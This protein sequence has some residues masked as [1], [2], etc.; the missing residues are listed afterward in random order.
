MTNAPKPDKARHSL[1]L[2][3]EWGSA[4]WCGTCWRR[5]DSPMLAG[6]VECKPC[7]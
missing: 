7:A 2:V 4:V 6:K 5:F 3:D 1:Q